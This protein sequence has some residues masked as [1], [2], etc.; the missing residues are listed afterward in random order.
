MGTCSLTS[1][2]FSRIA[3]KYTDLPVF[4]PNSEHKYWQKL[5]NTEKLDFVHTVYMEPGAD[6]GLSIGRV[7]LVEMRAKF[8]KPRPLSWKPRPFFVHIRQSD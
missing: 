7:L 3:S 5:K 4:L 8:L 6:P 1:A 2:F